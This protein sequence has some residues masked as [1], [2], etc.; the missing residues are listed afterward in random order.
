MQ[1]EC[2][3][4]NVQEWLCRIPGIDAYG[5]PIQSKTVFRHWDFLLRL[6]SSL[7]QRLRNSEIL[8]KLPA[9]TGRAQR[10]QQLSRGCSAFANRVRT[11]EP[12]PAS[13]R[14]LPDLS[15]E[16]CC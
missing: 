1:P 14:L 10:G 6:G 11:R 4:Q 5:T 9:S 13:V 2:V 15:L 7:S 3:S 8:L 16:R 12:D